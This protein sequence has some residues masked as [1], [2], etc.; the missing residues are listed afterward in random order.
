[1]GVELATQALS[2]SDYKRFQNNP[3]ATSIVVVSRVVNTDNIQ[4][5][6]DDRRSDDPT[7]Q[8]AALQHTRYCANR[9]TVA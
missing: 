6:L 8:V 1:M 7:R 4:V 2:W 5:L 9:C 3:R